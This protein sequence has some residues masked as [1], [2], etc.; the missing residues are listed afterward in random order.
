[1]CRSVSEAQALGQTRIRCDLPGCAG[2]AQ[3][4]Q[5]AAYNRRE[6]R[7]VRRNIAVA[8]KELTGGS[9]EMKRQFTSARPRE[10]A[11]MLAAMERIDP[12]FAAQLYEAA[13]GRL[14]GLHNMT[15]QESR[16]T[17]VDID[18]DAVGELKPDPGMISM[19]MRSIVGMESAY[20][21]SDLAR[22]NL[23]AGKLAELQRSANVRGEMSALGLFGHVDDNGRHVPPPAV[24]D[25]NAAQLAF[26][27]QTPPE[28]VARVGD[29]ENTIEDQF[30]AYAMTGVT[31]SPN[32]R[33]RLCTAEQAA[34]SPSQLASTDEFKENGRIAIRDGVEMVA[35]PDY[36]AEDPDSLEPAYHFV[37]DGGMKLPAGDFEGV[38]M[39]TNAIV[40]V[41][42]IEQR[43]PETGAAPMGQKSLYDRMLDPDTP[44][45][46]R[47][48]SRI[49]EDLIRATYTAGR[50]PG[51]DT[52]IDVTADEVAHR[53]G[54]RPGPHTLSEVFGTKSALSG[55]TRDELGRALNATMQSMGPEM[56]KAGEYSEMSY[57]QL[58]KHQE[59]TRKRFSDARRRNKAGR[60]RSMESNL[61]GPVISKRSEQNLGDVIT[62]RGH[63][64][65]QHRKMIL[66]G[67][68]HL[69]DEGGYG[70]IPSIPKDPAKAPKLGMSQTEKNRISGA[71]RTITGAD[72]ALMV[73]QANQASKVDTPEGVPTAALA[74][75]ARI[76]AAAEAHAYNLDRRAQ[77]RRKAPEGE[78]PAAPEPVTLE[79]WV[80]VPTG[81]NLHNSMRA[82]R[83]YRSN[84]YAVATTTRG[85]KPTVGAGEKAVRV[86]YTTHRGVPATDHHAVI[87]PDANFRIVNNK[88][89]T[90]H[91]MDE[92]MIVDESARLAAASS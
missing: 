32:R 29:I 42:K 4:Q 78:R 92:G 13:D 51:I 82:G 24:K 85:E 49:A 37:V 48:R 25:M 35:N 52:S 79:Q 55:K 61:A 56:E 9:Q 65:S 81:T 41:A 63:K 62:G 68:K 36:D 71:N 15:M 66:P 54:R 2:Y 19:G 45:G 30:V 46:Q 58:R 57:A 39:Q 22:E 90:I 11:E 10:L 50:I 5:L 34:L 28:A 80:V 59:A 40:S 31:F 64:E 76:R 73:A 60:N 74:A 12:T 3:K 86:V 67:L 47:V 87:P 23:S 38:G 77:A 6:A 69:R 16:R 84:G 18:H 91:V 17:T 75:E 14:P 26:Y 1:M 27:A 89:G 20:L 53:S 43:D 33:G 70:K 72:V 44:T 83:S 88:D 21:K 7:R 8:A